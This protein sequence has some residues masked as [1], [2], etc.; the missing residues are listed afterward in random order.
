MKRKLQINEIR[1]DNI[2]KITNNDNKMNVLRNIGRNLKKHHS[3]HH[4]EAGNAN[5]LTQK[6]CVNSNKSVCVWKQ[7]KTR[8]KTQSHE[9]STAQAYNT[10]TAQL[11]ARFTGNTKFSLVQISS[12][13][14]NKIL[15]CISPHSCEALV[16]WTAFWIQFYRITL[17]F[18]CFLNE[19]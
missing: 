15:K 7:G 4:S 16:W 9:W 19:F 11:P 18:S 14:Q 3:R 5:K 12:A 8:S 6:A 17:S 1:A 13:P 2:L 10:V